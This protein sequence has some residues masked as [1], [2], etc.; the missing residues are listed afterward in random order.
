MTCFPAAAP[1]T[2]GRIIHRR[3]SKRPMWPRV[4]WSLRSRHSSL[5][6]SLQPF[7]SQVLLGCHLLLTVCFQSGTATACPV[8]KGSDLATFRARSM[9][10]RRVRPL[11]MELCNVTLPIAYDTTRSVPCHLWADS[12]FTINCGVWCRDLGAR[13][14]CGRMC[15]IKQDRVVRAQRH[16]W[17]RRFY[18]VHVQKSRRAHTRRAPHTEKGP[19]QCGHGNKW[20]WGEHARCLWGRGVC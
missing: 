12:S 15:S 4:Q 3:T 16:L 6:E 2:S 11:L 7:Q 1:E 14:C 5:L 18:N 20:D 13:F 10:L 8:R 9:P 19:W 17:V